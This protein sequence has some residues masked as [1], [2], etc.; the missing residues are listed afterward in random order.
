MD[1]QLTYEQGN[2]SP[3]DDIENEDKSQTQKEIIASKDEK[4]ITKPN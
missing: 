4:V 3:I 1:D 2:D